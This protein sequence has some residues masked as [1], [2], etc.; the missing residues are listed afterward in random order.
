VFAL[1]LFTGWALHKAERR[2][3]IDHFLLLAN[4]SDTRSAIL[5]AFWVR[6]SR[7]KFFTLSPKNVSFQAFKAPM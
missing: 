5:R 3:E 4:L 6:F 2:G 1:S 7:S